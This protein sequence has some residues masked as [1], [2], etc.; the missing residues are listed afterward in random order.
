MVALAFAILSLAFVPEFIR[1][2]R[3]AF[4]IAPIVH[5]HA[6]IMAAWV[7]A[8]GVQVYLGAKGKIVQ[9]QRAGR[10]AFAIGWL[11]C[12]SMIFVEWRAMLVHPLPDQLPPYDEFLA[13]PYTYLTFALFLAWAFHER[14]RP[15]WHK[16]LML[17]AFFLSLGAAVQRYVW[18]PMTDTPAG[19]WAI[20]AFLD[21]ALL[22]PLLTFD[23]VTL[24]GR[25]H[26]ATVRA[27]AV[28][29]C[30]QAITLS[31]WGSS[32]WREF[33]YTFSHAFRQL[34]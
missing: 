6:A 24:R 33:A 3:G 12:A 31:L 2:A 5:V 15:M 21:A 23:V 20:L 19:C 18:L 7:L 4:P 14:R 29:F 9:H 32:A 8:F 16:R 10:I 27:M 1:Y 34:V 22:V 28:L 25:L 13:G 30:A 26:P 17:F 11:A